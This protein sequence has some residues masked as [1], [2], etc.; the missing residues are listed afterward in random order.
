MPSHRFVAAAVADL[1][2]NRVMSTAIEP[3][4]RRSI[5]EVCDEDISKITWLRHACVMETDWDEFD[6]WLNVLCVGS[7]RRDA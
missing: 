1:D 6:R 5:I 4:A 2:A 7:G 3:T